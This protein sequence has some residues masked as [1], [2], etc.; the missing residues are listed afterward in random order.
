MNQ[1][2]RLLAAVCLLVCRSRAQEVLSPPP[3]AAPSASAVQDFNANRAGT[4]PVPDASLG[5]LPLPTP[6]QW[7]PVQARPHLLYR[8]VYGDGVPSRNG[9]DK[10]TAIHE[11]SPGILLSLG[12][13]WALDY[14]PTWYTYSSS[15]FTDHVDQALHLNFGSTYHDW[16]LNL[17]H[18]YNASSASIVETGRQTEQE[19]HTTSFDADYSFNN[20][21]SLELGVVQ[22]LRFTPEFNDLHEWSTSDWL[23]YQLA[24]RLQVSAGVS[25]TYDNVETGVD[26]TSEQLLGR[27]SWHAGEKTMFEVHGGYEDRQI[28]IS[29]AKDLINPVF[30]LMGSYKPFTYTEIKLSAERVITPTFFNNQVSERLDFKGSL[31]QRLLGRVFFT[32]SGTYAKSDYVETLSD[33]PT[34]RHDNYYSVNFRL[35]TAVLKRGSISAF[36]TLSDNSSDNEAFAFTSNQSGLELGFN[37]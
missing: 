19:N 36:Y 24:P 17:I 11:V 16:M 30:G 18:D 6:F 7:G 34:I 15:N 12:T 35:T 20:Q 28:L 26:M 25:A 32:I 4:I 27:V 33:L 14:T 29:G 37:Y 1:T 22:H 8:F 2:L 31:R 9:L 10:T 13:H 5:E 3:T 21:W 23:V